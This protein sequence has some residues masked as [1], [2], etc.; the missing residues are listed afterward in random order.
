MYTDWIWQGT[1][2]HGSIPYIFLSKWNRS[3]FVRP[4][5]QPHGSPRLPSCLR[6]IS[7]SNRAFSS[8]LF[9]DV[10]CF[11]RNCIRGSLQMC[12][13][14]Q[15]DHARIDHTQLL[16]VYQQLILDASTQ[17]LW[18]HAGTS[19]PMRECG[20][21]RSQFNINLDNL[22]IS[23]ILWPRCKFDGLVHC[24]LFACPMLAVVLRKRNRDVGI[25]WALERVSLHNRVCFRMRIVQCD[26]A[27]RKRLVIGNTKETIWLDNKLA[28]GSV[29]FG[30]LM[31]QN[32]T[33]LF[34][35]SKKL[36][37]FRVTCWQEVDYDLGADLRDCL[38]E[39]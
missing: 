7:N 39:G 23:L 1:R 35:T 10:C 17:L 34:V 25:N 20:L 3:H 9:D 2:L 36:L 4:S 33:L 16:D 5:G 32:L 37:V 15:G 31:R 24:K 21:K 6:Q 38:F 29:S 30:E 8:S 13:R 26:R 11:L 19:A 28:D 12:S 18:H 22:R 14:N 27:S